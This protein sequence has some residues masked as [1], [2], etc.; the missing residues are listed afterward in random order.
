MKGQPGSS[1]NHHKTS[2]GLDRSVFLSL[3]SRMALGFGALF[4]CVLLLVGF[5][6]IFGIPFT[7][8]T[9]YYGQE[10]S[11]VLRNLS[12][13]AD[14]KKERLL[15]WLNERKGD[16]QVMAQSYAL[17]SF[18]RHLHDL[19]PLHANFPEAF[20]ELRPGLSGDKLYREAERRLEQYIEAYG[21]YRKIQVADVD[22]GVIV[23]STDE[24]D[25]GS[26]VSKSKFFTSALKPG[27][28]VSLDIER[29]PSSKSPY[30]LISKKVVDPISRKHGVNTAVGVVIM[31][32][33]AD[34]FI[35][36]L[37]YT[38]RGLG[39]SGDIVLVNQDMRILISPKYPLPKAA[40]EGLMEYRIQ[41]EPARLAAAGS[42]GIVV[43]KDYRGESVL[44]AY[45]HISVTRDS[46]WGMVVKIDQSEVF[47]QLRRDLSHSLII[48]LLG[49][50][51]AVGLAVLI[52]TKISRPIHL[53]SLT[54]R[55]VEA[56]NLD[57]RAPIVSK[58]EVGSLAATFN[59]MIGSVQGWYQELD[60]QVRLRTDQL[61]ELNRHLTAEVAERKRAE[62]RIQKQND[63]VNNVLE[64]LSH[65]FYVVDTANYKVTLANSS[66]TAGRIV[67]DSTCYALT[68]D[69]ISP[70]AGDNHPCPLGEVREKRQPVV[71]EHIHL[72]RDGTS[73]T[74]E[75]HAHPVFDDKGDVSQVIEYSLD[76][77]DRKRVEQEREA[78][79]AELEAKNV[80]LERFTY[81][82]S[83]DLSSPL[84]TIKTFAE[85]IREGLS[86][87]DM[88]SVQSDL[89]RITR[90]ADRMGRL[91]GRT[92]GTLANR[93]SGQSIR[94]KYPWQSS[95]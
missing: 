63:F 1:T 81:T 39:E 79:I 70:C 12:L 37:L 27:N 35:K 54:A 16:A 88:E 29:L 56:G 87:G 32:I 18:I 95:F 69:A 86:D 25:L 75:I 85:F 42:E 74:I 45:R 76:I 91:L 60:E 52:A 36:P 9:G 28:G 2:R 3:R 31:Y 14:L 61:T 93:P 89:T 20:H 57:A 72:D 5:S 13:V 73:R 68:H 11:Q 90:A 22:K 50:L 92:L 53:L 59:S 66:A 77:T 80:E 38:G 43:G 47:G 83:H 58:D 41:A 65:P 67:G 84:I 94:L 48:G 24:R 44:A 55:E 19:I 8:N 34:A 10:K 51:G 6:M 17:T 15:V 30:L 40:K 78:L 4:T 21:A 62:A 26:D 46:G 71:T 7:S 82:V 33:D 49:I 64:S 23:V